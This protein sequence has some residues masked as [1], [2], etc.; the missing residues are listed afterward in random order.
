MLMTQVSWFDGELGLQELIKHV[1][2]KSHFG[3]N[4]GLDNDVAI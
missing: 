1:I 3:K 2:H 4:P